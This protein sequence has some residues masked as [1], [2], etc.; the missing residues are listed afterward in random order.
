M[1]GWSD[2]TM[3][4]TTGLI[5]PGLISLANTCCLPGTP[6]RDTSWWNIKTRNVFLVGIH[7]AIS[8]P[9]TVWNHNKSFSLQQT[10]LICISTG[11]N[12]WCWLHGTKSGVCS[13]GQ[14]GFLSKRLVVELVILFGQIFTISIVLTTYFKI[15]DEQ[16]C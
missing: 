14:L 6:E 7:W 13:H 11:R 3:L 9:K 8:P 5:Q 10:K 4:A 12:L 15:A 2:C 16:C 1:E